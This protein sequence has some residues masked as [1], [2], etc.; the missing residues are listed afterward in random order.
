MFALSEGFHQSQSLQTEQVG[1]SGGRTYL[2][3]DCKFGA[4]ARAPVEEAVE[5]S[6]SSGLTYR[7]GN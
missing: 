1:A 2:G 6:R 7:S 4:G 5:H 3:D